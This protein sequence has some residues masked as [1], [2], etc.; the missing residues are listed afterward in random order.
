MDITIEEKLRLLQKMREDTGR[1]QNALQIRSQIIGAPKYSYESE[2]ESSETDGNLSF[3]VRFF[4]AVLLF[5]GYL[6]LQYSG[7]SIGGISAT[8]M[9]DMIGET[10]N[11]NLFDFSAV[12]P[13]TLE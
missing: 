12:L 10:S 6:L 2:A 4:C 7:Q 1:N 3:K 9:V 11:T 13:Y 5:V 8:D